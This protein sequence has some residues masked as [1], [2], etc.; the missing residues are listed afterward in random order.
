[1]GW[2]RTKLYNKRDDSDFPIV[3]VPF[4][5]SNIPAALAYMEYIENISQILI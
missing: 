5:C 2:L 4:I 1:V 3:K